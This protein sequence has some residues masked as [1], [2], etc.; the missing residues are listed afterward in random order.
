MT[1]YLAQ[2]RDELIRTYRDGLL[3]DVIPFWL[4]HGLDRKHGGIHTALGRRG[5]LLDSDK[6]VWFQ[7][8]AAQPQS[9]STKARSGAG[10][11]ARAVRASRQSARKR[12]TPPN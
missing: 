10:S 7:G 5:E 6:S 8:R 3:Q 1:P 4:K 11:A 9:P 2:R 12:G